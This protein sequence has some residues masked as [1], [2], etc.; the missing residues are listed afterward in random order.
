MPEKTTAI[1]KLNKIEPCR[2]ETPFPDNQQEE[3]HLD[4]A[5]HLLEKEKAAKLLEQHGIR[6]TAKVIKHDFRMINTKWWMAAAILLLLLSTYVLYQYSNSSTP[7]QLAD[8]SLSTVTDDYNFTMRSGS[9]TAEI[10][11]AQIAIINKNWTLADKHLEKALSSV[12]PEDSTMIINIYFYKGV[13]SLKK[14]D[15]ET[16]VQ[17]FNIAANS[18]TGVLRNDAIWLRGLSY[19]KLGKTDEAI[20]DMEHTAKLKEW[21]KANDAKKILE[22]LKSEQ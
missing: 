1:I 5:F 10:R 6:R 7:E 2:M 16:A 12:A 13:V 9:V 3:R 14:P 15:Y 8:S 20:K 19:I 18:K 17:N 11:D 4:R 21:K 22:T